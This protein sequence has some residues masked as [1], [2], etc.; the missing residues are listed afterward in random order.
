MLLEPRTAAPGALW[1]WQRQAAEL[2]WR[3]AGFWL[4]LSLLMCLTMFAAHRWPL[5]EGVLAVT[6][7]LACVLIAAEIDRRIRA[8]MTD[9]ALPVEGI[10]E[11]E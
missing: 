1:R 4:G 8:K 9:V 2:L 7:L 6:S 3:G 5:L 11:A 10:E